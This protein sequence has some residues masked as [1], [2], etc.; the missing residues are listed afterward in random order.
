MKDS[1]IPSQI[2]DVC[3]QSTSLDI[4]RVVGAGT[5]FHDFFVLYRDRVRGAIYLAGVL[6]TCD[7]D[8]IPDER[9]RQ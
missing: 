7:F 8:N 4:E 2:V 1:G 5:I 9:L 3:K 6:E